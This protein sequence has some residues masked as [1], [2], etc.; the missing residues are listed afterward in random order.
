MRPLTSCAKVGFLSLL[1]WTAACSGA[2]DAPAVVWTG[3]RP[4]DGGAGVSRDLE[5]RLGTISPLG[6]G[7]NAMS[8]EARGSCVDGTRQTI[9]STEP[10]LRRFAQ[11]FSADEAAAL[12]SFA[13]TPQRFESSQ[14]V[15]PPEWQDPLAL[16]LVYGVEWR[17]AQEEFTSGTA[18]LIV[19]ATDASFR[20]RCG[21]AYY[22]QADLGGR[23]L[24]ELTLR[25]STRAAHDDFVRLLGT[26]PAIWDLGPVTSAHPGLF[27]GKLT[28]WPTIR[29]VGGNEAALLA[30]LDA[31]ALVACWGEPVSSCNDLLQQFVAKALGTG[32]ESTA[33]SISAR[34]AWLGIRLASYAD[35]GGPVTRLRPVAVASA[36]T[37]LDAAYAE[38]SRLSHRLRTLSLYWFADPVAYPGG[39]DAASAGVGVNRL[40]LR[41]A[42]QRCFGISGP[43]DAAGIATCLD[44]ASPA[45]LAALG[46]DFRLTLDAFPLP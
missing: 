7:W 15:Q 38:Q 37:A 8:S 43:D 46:F 23:L 27:A 41:F 28:T 11:P 22:G 6:S 42:A 25:F 1:I 3:A 19:S 40:W 32:P 30:G 45:T 26:S 34:P 17:T 36:L 20:G 31:D 9:P 21:D 14:G 18:S 2:E 4:T 13:L 29:M 44:A 39:I 33:E 24:L 35:L 16:R 5:A 12:G 10:T